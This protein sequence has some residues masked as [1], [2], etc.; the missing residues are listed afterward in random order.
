MPYFQRKPIEGLVD[1]IRSQLP[2]PGLP[3][4]GSAMPGA[5]IAGIQPENPLAALT[6]IVEQATAV[7][8]SE[9]PSTTAPPAA[10]SD[11]GSVPSTQ[12]N[13]VSQLQE[14]VNALIEQLSALLGRPM[15][16]DAATLPYMSAPLQGASSDPAC[17][18][19]EPAP[20]LSP[21]G[22]IAP[23]GTAQIS[24]SLVNEDEQPGQIVFFS[25]GL[26]SEDGACI[27]SERVSFQPRELTLEPGNTGEV[28]V[29]V[30]VPAQT[31]CGVYSGLIRAS[32]LDYLHAVVV[33]Q[34]DYP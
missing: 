5:A 13:R 8:A 15:T 32:R 27:P 33:V 18:V 26:I 24:I 20:V 10:R 17:L 6:G 9:R 4:R 25:T 29:R 2:L 21:A 23:G 11:V 31:R 19:V 28:I 34:V 14:Q 1:T 12:G 22:A 30:V 3:S 16:L 7:L